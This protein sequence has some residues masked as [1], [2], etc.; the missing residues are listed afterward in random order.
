M[1]NRGIG[2]FNPAKRLARMARLTALLLARRFA[3]AARGGFFNPSLGGGLP[4][5]LL[6]NPS[7]RSSSASR[8]IGTAF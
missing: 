7:R 5:L 6:F 1:V 2:C 4:L 3:K 8:P